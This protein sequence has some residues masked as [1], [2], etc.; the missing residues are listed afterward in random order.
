MGTA[1]LR[2]QIASMI[3][4]IDQRGLMAAIAAKSRPGAPFQSPEYSLQKVELDQTHNPKT[5][6]C[7]CP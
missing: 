3:S 2:V 7:C 1:S 4:V 5:G 6:A